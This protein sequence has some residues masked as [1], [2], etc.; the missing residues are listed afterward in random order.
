MVG[1]LQGRFGAVL[2]EDDAGWQEAGRASAL[3]S[4]AGG[5]TWLEQGAATGRKTGLSAAP[6]AAIAAR[7]VMEIFG[8]EAALWFG[9]RLGRLRLVELRNWPE[10]STTRR[11]AQKSAA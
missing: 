11:R 4:G 5:E 8:R 7:I 6:T 10:G 9:R 1:L 2:V 3:E